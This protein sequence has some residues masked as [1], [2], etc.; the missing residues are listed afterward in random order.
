MKSKVTKIGIIGGSGVEQLIFTEGFKNKTVKTEY[1]NVPVKV[2]DVAGRTIVFLSRH[3]KE[4]AL[5]SNVN[6]RANIKAMQSEGV[7]NIICTAAVGGINPRMRPGEFALLTDFIDFTRGQRETF[8]VHSFIDLSEPYSN[9][10]N[11]KIYN[12]ATKLRVKLHPGATYVC[13]EGPRFETKAEIK[14]FAKL[15]GDLVG[16]TQVPEVV[17]AA[18]VGIPYAGIAVITN[19]AAGISRKKVSPDEVIEVMKQRSKPLS[20]LILKTIKS[21]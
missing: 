8:T 19:Y 18:E 20:N 4:Y 3:G 7:E 12:V 11:K 17:L 14:M 6:Y 2:G 9:Y 5:P 21:L 16:M 10:L 15:G 13:T 1:G